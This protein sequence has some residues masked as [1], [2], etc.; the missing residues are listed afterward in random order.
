[1]KKGSSALAQ[2]TT[3]FPERI[4]SRNETLHA[5]SSTRSMESVDSIGIA[6]RGPGRQPIE[7]V[8]DAVTRTRWHDSRD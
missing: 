1:M 6:L 5:P 2:Q 4:Y 7:A 8:L 3:N